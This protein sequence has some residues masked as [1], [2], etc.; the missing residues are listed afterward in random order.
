[1]ASLLLGG[2]G[3]SDCP[4]GLP[5]YHPVGSWGAALQPLKG[6]SLISPVGP[7]YG[8]GGTTVFQWCLAG[9]ELLLSKSF[10]SY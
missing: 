6:E 10:L 7:W 5:G 1:M 8:W 2:G 3:S 9:V 4:L